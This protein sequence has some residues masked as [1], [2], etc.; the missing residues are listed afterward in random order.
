MDTDAFELFKHTN[1]DSVLSWMKNM[2]I[3]EYAVVT[4]VIDSNTVRV[5]LLIQNANTPKVFTVRLLNIGSSRL[6]E[7][8]VQP[9]VYDQVLLLFLRSYDEELML[10]PELREAATG[11]SALHRESTD[12]YNLFTGVGILASPSRNR[13]PTKIHYGLDA[14]GPYI[15]AET[16]AKIMAAF[17]AAMS[18]VFDVPAADEGD[19]PDDAP[20]NM[21]FG[22]QVPVNLEHRANVT[23]TVR[24]DATFEVTM[25]DGA[26]VSVVSEDGASLEFTKAFSIKADQG[27]TLE[28][29]AEIKLKTGD[30]AGWLPNCV[31]ACPFGFPHGGPTGGI[32]K[33]KGE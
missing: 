23:I 3:L 14:T 12:S 15:N 6:I 33:L 7:E 8:T 16:S 24:K 5:K 1:L 26:T 18:L 17:K 31:A 9:Q 32:V 4:K 10:D 29:N 25:E 2:L 11:D 27:I 28:S 20:L 19:T 22:R 21:L 13:A 30:A